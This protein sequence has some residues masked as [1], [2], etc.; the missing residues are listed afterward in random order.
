M[1]MKQDEL[2]KKVTEKNEEDAQDG[3]D[4]RI[5]SGRNNAVVRSDTKAWEMDQEKKKK[6]LEKRSNQF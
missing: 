6:G 5:L 2:G 4:L 3:Q 1:T